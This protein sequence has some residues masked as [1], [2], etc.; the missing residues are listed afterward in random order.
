ME[1]SVCDG[2]HIKLL[3]KV[4]IIL[5][6][7]EN[8][9]DNNAMKAIAW[10]SDNRWPPEPASPGRFNVRESLDDMYKANETIN[11]NRI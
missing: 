3:K 11:G 1:C 2:V 4:H 5:A 9:L 6:Y 8:M 10:V 7:E